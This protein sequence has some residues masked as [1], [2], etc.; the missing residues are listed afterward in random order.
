MEITVVRIR[1]LLYGKH[2]TTSGEL[3]SGIMTV[4]STIPRLFIFAFLITAML[5]VGLQTSAGDLRAVLESKGFFFRC[6]LV[7]FAVIPVAGIL[8][9]RILPME[10]HAAAAFL[11]LA[12]TPGG[13]TALQFGTRIKGVSLYAAGSSFLLSFLAVFV[14]PVWLAAVFPHSLSIKVPYGRAVFFNLL[15]LLFPLAAGA[16]G[17]RRLGRLAAKASKVCAMISLVCFIVFYILIYSIRKQALDAVGREGLLY[18]LMFVIVSMTAGW[19][20]GGPAIETRAVL[21]TVSGMR[22]VALC[23]LLTLN[24]FADPAVQTNMVA[25]SAIMIPPGTLLTL[26]MYLH[27]RRY[28]RHT[29]IRR[30]SR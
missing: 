30:Y 19:L 7:N 15:Y 11:L 5:S 18:M 4:I 21:A 27:L 29:S 25:F 1:F 13:I 14:S 28:K 17:R 2:V 26:Y 23:I 10:S 12:C 22:N 16:W 9:V 8:M 24:T 20:L 3:G 6:L